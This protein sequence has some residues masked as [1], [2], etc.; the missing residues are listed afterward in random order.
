ME[1][2]VDAHDRKLS[3][4]VLRKETKRYFR[5]VMESVKAV[6]NAQ[7]R[8]VKF[9]GLWAQKPYHLTM[10]RTAFIFTLPYDC[11][12]LPCCWVTELKEAVPVIAQWLSARNVHEFLYASAGIITPKKVQEIAPGFVKIQLYPLP[13]CWVIPDPP[14]P[15]EIT[16]DMEQLYMG[17]PPMEGLTEASFILYNKY[18]RFELR[19]ISEGFFTYANRITIYH[20]LN[21]L[22]YKYRRGRIAIPLFVENDVGIRRLRLIATSDDAPDEERCIAAGILSHISPIGSMEDPKDYGLPINKE[23]LTSPLRALSVIFMK[24]LS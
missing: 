9:G 23:R 12:Y 5:K 17:M 4:H 22:K 11:P 1:I 15:I 16:E 6:C 7:G 10:P 8:M 13:I 14:P 18:L 2:L 24:Q 20:M 3:V 19:R 21:E